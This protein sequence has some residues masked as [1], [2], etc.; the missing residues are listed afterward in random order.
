MIRD[1]KYLFAYT[2]PLAAFLG[3]YYGGIWSLGAVYV[4]F[5]LI[6]LLELMLPYSKENLSPKV[7]DKKAKLVFFDLLL[8]LNIPILYG[9]I[10][11][12]FSTIQAGGLTTFEMFGMT[13]NVGIL[14]STIG[15][16]VAH[17]LGH[18][19]T[20]Y[21]QFMSKTL[22]LS[23]LYLHFYIEHNRGHH[24]NVATYEDPATSRLG[25][26]VYAFWF[27]SITQSY[28]SAWRLEAQRLTREGKK[29]ISTDNQMIW[30]QITQLIYL[31]GIGAIFGW[32]MI[33]Y[34]IFIALA[35][36]ILLETVNYIEHYG[37]RRKKLASGRY[38][39]VEPHHSW[40]SNHELGRIFLYELTRHSDH[41]FKA[42]R[43][44][45]LLRHFD[46]SPQLPLGYPASMVLALVPPIWFRYMDGK[47]ER[48][49]KVG[50]V[51]AVEKG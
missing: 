21:E 51:E 18:R 29:V 45:Q 28:L 46:E 40:N 24:K 47:V 11:Y 36:V 25:E 50:K 7:A 26:S 34:A 10:L 6:P 22:L 4:A 43:K 41:H 8:Y 16:N 33:P 31:L 32:E 39:N 38:E 14:V 20:K 1:A 37:L 17:E 27:R 23:A 13:L 9:L 35:G 15:I 12:Y 48:V 30:F 5:G 2:A 42:T 19:T 44:Y 3:I 49:Q